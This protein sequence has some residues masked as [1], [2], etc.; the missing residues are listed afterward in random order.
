MLLAKLKW[1]IRVAFNRDQP[2]NHYFQKWVRENPEKPCIIEIETGRV[3]TFKQINEL[4]NKY[5]NLFAVRCF[6]N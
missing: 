6:F 1:K 5:A 4:S 3:L 2:L